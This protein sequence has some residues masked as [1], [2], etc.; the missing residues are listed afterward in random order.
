MHAFP[1]KLCEQYTVNISK[2]CGA[3]YDIKNI[4]VINGLDEYRAMIYE[5]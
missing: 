2:V 3:D 1:P 4:K 5:F